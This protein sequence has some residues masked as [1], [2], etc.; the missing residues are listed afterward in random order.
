MRIDEL[1]RELHA[2]AAETVAGATVSMA[3]LRDRRAR[4]RRRR[5]AAGGTLAVALLAVGAGLARPAPPHSG[6]YRPGPPQRRPL[7]PPS[8]RSGRWCSA[9]VPSSVAAPSPPR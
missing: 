7:R 1:R 5:A 8:S 3:D 2:Q 6:S 9:A 4:S